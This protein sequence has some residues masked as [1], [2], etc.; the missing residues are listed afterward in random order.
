MAGRGGGVPCISNHV[1]FRNIFS[2]GNFVVI[3]YDD[4]DNFL[5]Y[6]LK[7]IKKNKKMLKISIWL[8]V[9]KWLR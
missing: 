2:N 9:E 1:F 7:I 4:S 6:V 8:V 3:L 5:R